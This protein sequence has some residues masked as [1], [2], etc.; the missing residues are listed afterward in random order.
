MV[1]IKGDTTSRGTSEWNLLKLFIEEKSS[2]PLVV[3]SLCA[4]SPD[5]IAPPP[6]LH[7]TH[8]WQPVWVRAQSWERCLQLQ[9]TGPGKRSLCW[10]VRG[11]RGSHPLPDDT[12][13]SQLS[14]QS[15][16]V[17]CDSSHSLVV[18][19]LFVFTWIWYDIYISSNSVTSFKVTVVKVKLGDLRIEN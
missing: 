17:G 2:S 14:C 13:Q 7:T 16:L 3:T 10:R 9:L 15:D 11:E 12:G 5:C 1:D 18:S 4:A 19:F 8:H 6:P